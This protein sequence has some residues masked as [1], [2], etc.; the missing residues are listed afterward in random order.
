MRLSGDVTEKLAVSKLER[1]LG[2]YVA[3]TLKATAHCQTA[4]RKASAALRLLKMAFPT[5]KISNFKQLYTTY[6][7]PHIEYC[8]QAVGP[9]LRKDIKV[10]ESVQCRATKLVRAIRH[11]PY[12]ARLKKLKLISIEQRLRR[13]DLIETYKIVTNK[14]SVDPTEFFK[15]SEDSRTRGHSLKLEMR[16]CNLKKCSKFFSNRVV[17]MWNQL[18]SEVTSA[19]TVNCFKNRLDRHWTESSTDQ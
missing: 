6:V 14:V 17:A 4:A 10:L 1:D 15:H 5:L 3:D 12:E 11:L 2:V 13:G 18:P 8:M 9:F 7:R 19:Q 16:C